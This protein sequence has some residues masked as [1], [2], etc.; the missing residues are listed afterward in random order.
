MN[1]STFSQDKR[2]LH[3]SGGGE[4]VTLLFKPYWYVLP[5][6]RRFGLKMGID[7]ARFGLESGI[8]FEGARVVYDH[9][10]ARI[11]AVQNF[12]ARIVSNTRK[13]MTG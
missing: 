4:G 11:Q 8:V 2:K 3:V 9:N 10:L 6:R 7:F 13:C 5:Q 1:W 12:A